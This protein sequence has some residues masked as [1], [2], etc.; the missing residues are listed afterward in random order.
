MKIY[1]QRLLFKV[2]GKTPASM[3]MVQYWKTGEMVEARIVNVDG[4]QMM[5]MNGEK[6][7]F[8]GFPR[9]YLLFGPLSKLKHE[10]K[11]QIFNDSWKLLGEKSEDEVAE[12]IQNTL[13]GLYA[14]YEQHKYDSVPPQRMVPAVREIHR[15]WTKVSPHSKLRDML[16]F[17]LQEDDGYRFR[18]QWMVSF[19]PTWTFRFIDPLKGFETGLKW[20]ENAE[21]IGDMKERIRLLRTI[22]L[23]ALKNRAFREKF[24]RLFR[25]VDW[26]KVKL[27]KADRY[28]FR[29]KWFKVDLDKFDY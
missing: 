11:N 9:G 3:E 25:E 10:I 23:V 26:K 14:L 22:L 13:P 29:G 24:V 1:L 21:I 8:P 19:M 27:S 6:Y 16:C 12:Y 28:F 4:A 7:I 18:L 15:A 2:L 20:L 5:K 17:I